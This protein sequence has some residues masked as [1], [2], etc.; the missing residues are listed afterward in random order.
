V[1]QIDS[2]LAQAQESVAAPIARDE[3]R[4]FV[5]REIGS[6]ADILLAD[7]VTAKNELR[8]YISELVLTP[9]GEG[10]DRGYII[11]GDI[12]LF[13][14]GKNNVMQEDFM[15]RKPLHY[16]IAVHFRVQGSRRHA[17]YSGEVKPLR[18]CA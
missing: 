17:R 10:K 1:E 2:L 4:E 16:I 12:T 3:V 15:E 18:L 11:S 6:I 7:P 14:M 8:K 9:F 13:Q 5:E